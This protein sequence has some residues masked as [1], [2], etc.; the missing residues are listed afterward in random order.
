[1]TSPPDTMSRKALKRPAS[2][3]IYEIECFPDRVKLEDTPVEL[4][5]VPKHSEC[6]SA[7]QSSPTMRNTVRRAEG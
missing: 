5:L 4:S 3:D 7:V 6:G 2:G 1:M